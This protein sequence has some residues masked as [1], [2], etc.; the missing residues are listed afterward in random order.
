MGNLDTIRADAGLVKKLKQHV[1]D[2]HGKLHGYLVEETETALKN[3]LA[4][5]GVVIE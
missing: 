2:K 1:I 3:H 4:A 5:Q